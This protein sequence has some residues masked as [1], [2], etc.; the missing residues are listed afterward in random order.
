M[1]LNVCTAG[2]P[3]SSF[4]PSGSVTSS[5]RPAGSPFSSGEIV[6]TTMSPPLIMFERQPSRV[7]MLMLVI[8]QV[9]CFVVPSFCFTSSSRYAC[10]LVH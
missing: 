1:R 3:G 9:K 4:L 7:I 6:A 2:T 5:R 8:S 10:G